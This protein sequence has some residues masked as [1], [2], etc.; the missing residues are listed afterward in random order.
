MARPSGESF[1][2]FGRIVK[3]RV[4]VIRKADLTIAHEQGKGNT[5][6]LDAIS[7]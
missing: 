3:L 4:R 1:S 7:R 6:S 2:Q 5:E